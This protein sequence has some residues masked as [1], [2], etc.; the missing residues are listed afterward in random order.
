MR[1]G[2]LLAEARERGSDK[3][4]TLDFLAVFMPSYPKRE[5]EIRVNFEGIPLFGKLDGYNPWKK[6][7]GE[8]KTGKN[9]TQRMA[10]QSDQLTM[11]SLMVWKKSR[12]IPQ[13]NLHWAKTIEVQGLS[14][15]GDFKTFETSRTLKDFILLSKRLKIAWEGI[16]EMGKELNE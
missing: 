8:D 2:K 11:Y 6:I 10:D 1:L 9:F 12:L 3:D 14:L 16:L 4:P 7:I 13:I 15:T 5:Y